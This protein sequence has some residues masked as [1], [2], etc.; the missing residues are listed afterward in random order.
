[1]QTRLHK[2]IA[3]TGYCSRRKAEELMAAGRVTVNGEKVKKLGTT[4]DPDHDVVMVNRILLTKVEQ[5]RYL[6]VNKPKGVVCTRAQYKTEKTV[7]DII[8]DVRE[9]VIAGRLDKDSDGLIIMTNDGELTNKLTHPR[10]LHEKEYEVVTVKPISEAERDVLR[11]GV[12][13]TEGKAG[14]D[15]IEQ[16]GEKTYR[17]IMH[18]GWKRQIRRMF[19]MVH[20]DVQKLTRVRINKLLLGGLNPGASREVKRSDIV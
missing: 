18:Q 9:L 5:Y 19:G 8:P 1:M 6:A 4:I 11:A 2:F 15:S 13:L 14:F 17:V 12:R 7:Y 3:N 10:Y 20:A 16:V